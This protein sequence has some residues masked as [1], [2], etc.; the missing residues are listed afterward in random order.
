M[1]SRFLNWR[2]RTPPSVEAEPP[3]R[4]FAHQEEVIVPRRAA[5]LETMKRWC[6][7]K[8]YRVIPPT[9]QLGETARWCFATAEDAEFFQDAF[10]GKITKV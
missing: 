7:G 8:P 1:P 10:G 9:P 6:L 5:T 3:S 2:R 4:S